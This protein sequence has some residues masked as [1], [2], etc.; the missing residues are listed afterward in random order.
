MKRLIL[1]TVL[2]WST[3]I[4]FVRA[5][6]P[7][8][9]SWAA[10]RG[11]TYTDTNIIP[12]L[13]DVLT[14]IGWHYTSD[15]TAP[16][17]RSDTS[18]VFTG[19]GQWLGVTFVAS[20]SNESEFDGYGEMD[21]VGG[22]VVRQYRT[23][24]GLW[25]NKDSTLISNSAVVTDTFHVWPHEQLRIIGRPVPAKMPDTTGGY[26]RSMCLLVNLYPIKRGRH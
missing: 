6:C 18:R 19:V 16:E 1:I 7:N 3:A 13:G 4:A 17:L 11:R 21:S 22:Y 15:T 14:G 25:I 26:Y 24:P 23:P 2:L 20:F 10:V 9:E 12:Q 5:D 8:W